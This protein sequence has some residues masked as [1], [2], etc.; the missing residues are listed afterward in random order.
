MSLSDF[1]GLFCIR[2]FR[3]IPGRLMIS[4]TKEMTSK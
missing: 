4:E 2:I 1:I 3:P